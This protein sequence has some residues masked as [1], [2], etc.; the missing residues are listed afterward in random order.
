[1]E[2]M[3]NLHNVIMNV[4]ET[5]E[6]GVVNKDTLF[7]F[8]QRNTLVSAEYSG[9]KIAKGYLVGS[10]INNVLTFTYCQIQDDGTLDNGKSCAELEIRDGKLRLIEYFEW[11]SRPGERGVNIFEEIIG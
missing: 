8:Q 10:L 3:I 5:S 2:K 9:G 7:T 1:M 6:N 4:I 11:T